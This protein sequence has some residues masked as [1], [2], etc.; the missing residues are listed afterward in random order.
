MEQKC[1]WMELYLRGSDVNQDVAV[2]IG[3]SR[4]DCFWTLGERVA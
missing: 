4:L 3:S 1:C 2:N